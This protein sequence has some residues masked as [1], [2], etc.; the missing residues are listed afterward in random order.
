MGVYVIVPQ[1]MSCGQRL[2][3]FDFS[4]LKISQ[5]E[6][7]L[8]FSYSLDCHHFDLGLQLCV[9]IWA[10]VKD[11]QHWLTVVYC[12]TLCY[13]S[14]LC[15]WKQLMP[16]PGCIY[17]VL[18]LLCTLCA[19]ARWVRGPYSPRSL[20]L[21]SEVFTLWWPLTHGPLAS[22]SGVKTCTT[23]P[24]SLPLTCGKSLIYPKT[25]MRGA[26]YFKI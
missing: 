2:D 20:L 21:L 14:F 13:V 9:C 6:L 15:V 11:N 8:F 3:H 22:A 18:S 19:A 26:I 12:Q 24:V 1:P 5:I 25:R 7:L 4:L 23:I 10:V 16:C 17:H